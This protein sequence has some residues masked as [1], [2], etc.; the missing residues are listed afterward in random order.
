MAVANTRE[1]PLTIVGGPRYKHRGVVM[2][3]EARG[4]FKKIDPHPWKVCIYN[5]LRLVDGAKRQCDV[6]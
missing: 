3:V 2:T 6:Q 5:H 4:K 1:G